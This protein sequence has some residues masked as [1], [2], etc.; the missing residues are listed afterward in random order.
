MVTGSPRSSAT[1][2]LRLLSRN[3]FDRSRQFGPVFA[4]LLELEREIVLD[5]EIAA[6]D[7]RGVTHLDDLAAAIAR[8]DTARSPTSRF[9]LLHLDGHDLRDCALVDRKALLAEVLRAAGCPRLVYV[10]HVESGGDRLLEAVREVGAEG[11]VAKRRTSLYRAGP[12]REWLKTK[13]SEVGEFVVTGFRDVAPG[14]IEAVKVAQFV[15]DELL[16]VGEV[17]FGVGRGLRDVLE[18]L[19]LNPAPGARTVP[20]RPMLAAEVKYFGRHRS[21]AIRDGVLRRWCGRRL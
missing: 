15:E 5:G 1:A 17:R 13:C 18:E 12:S 7:D 11:I 10:D 8:R 16:P 6:P 4:G 14:K 21:G 3:A 19:R 9:D 20:V 2:A